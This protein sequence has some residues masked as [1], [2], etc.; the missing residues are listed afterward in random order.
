MQEQAAPP[1]LVTNGTGTSASFDVDVEKIN[2]LEK[3][4]R[5]EVQ[6]FEAKERIQEQEKIIA[7][8]ALEIEQKS[9]LVTAFRKLKDLVENQDFDYFLSGFTPDEVQV[10]RHFIGEIHDTIPEVL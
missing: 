4:A 5:L 2:Y 9:E 1:A 7:D 3:I 6:L 8:Q 10:F